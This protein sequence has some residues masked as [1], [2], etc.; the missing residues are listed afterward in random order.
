[1]KQATISRLRQERERRGWSR[2]YV[3]EKIEVDVITV[4]RWERGER[5]PHPPCRQKLCALF[6]MNAEDLGLFSESP[7]SCENGK[8]TAEHPL[9]TLETMT[10]GAELAPEEQESHARTASA[11]PS[12]DLPS[13]QQKSV[14]PP[15]SL[16]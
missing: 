6:E 15:S 2:S 16:L 5:M 12:Q 4:G 13:P 8:G 9:E 1:M 11:S 14:P 3:A 10:H 7:R